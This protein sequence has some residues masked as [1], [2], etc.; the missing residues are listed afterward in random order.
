MNES[1]DRKIFGEIEDVLKREQIV[2]W[3][4]SQANRY[5]IDSQTH[6]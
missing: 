4:G 2:H 6:R 3:L 1:K 5:K